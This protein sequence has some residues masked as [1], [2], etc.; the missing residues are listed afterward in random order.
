VSNSASHSVR[1]KFESQ[2]GD[3]LF[4]TVF[5]THRQLPHGTTFRQQPAH[6]YSF[7]LS[8][9]THEPYGLT[10]Q[11]VH[12]YKFSLNSELASSLEETGLNLYYYPVNNNKTYA[13]RARHYFC[14]HRQRHK[15]I[16]LKKQE[17]KVW[18]RLI[19]YNN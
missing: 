16:I 8:T 17:G 12:N 11:S 3:L 7:I 13:S 10:L 1:R 19:C 5:S 2:L 9:L 14:E 4:A 15:R 18:I 6:V